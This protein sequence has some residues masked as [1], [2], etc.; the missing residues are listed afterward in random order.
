MLRSTQVRVV[1]ATLADAFDAYLS[2]PKR[3]NSSDI[4]RVGN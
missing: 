4:P 3:P 2:K 1:K